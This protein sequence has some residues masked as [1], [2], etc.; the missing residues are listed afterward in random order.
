VNEQPNSGT[1]YQILMGTM[2]WKN[3]MYPNQTQA[4]PV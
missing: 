1:K 3:I 4:K 2:K